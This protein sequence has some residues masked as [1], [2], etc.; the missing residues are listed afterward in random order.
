MWLGVWGKRRKELTGEEIYWAYRNRYDI[1]HFF[2]FGKQK[3]LLDKYQTPDEEH[4]QNRMEVVNLTYW[5]L[6]VGKKEAKHDCR[7]WQQYDKNHKKRIQQDLN[8]TPS[9]VQLQMAGI[10]LGF[11]Q[12]PFLPKAKIK[13]KGRKK[14]QTQEKRKH[15]PILKKQKKKKKRPEK[16]D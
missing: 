3:L 14:G 12:T 16:Q 6:F 15:F 7:K 8:V 4:L 1:E 11:E 2:R 13:G 10:I 9:Q 5:L